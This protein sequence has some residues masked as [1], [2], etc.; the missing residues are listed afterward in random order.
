MFAARPEAGY[1]VHRECSVVT[2]ALFVQA[3]VIVSRFFSIP[4]PLH[5]P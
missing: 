2:G 5:T 1:P 3:N 4:L